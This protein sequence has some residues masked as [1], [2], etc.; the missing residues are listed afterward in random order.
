MKELLQLRQLIAMLLVLSIA[1]TSCKCGGDKKEDK[2]EMYDTKKPITSFREGI[3]NM[4]EL[5]QK[6]I[7][8]GLS[9][10]F[11][12]ALWKDRLAEALKLK[13][14]DE[15]KNLLQAAM[16]RI[17]Q[18]IYVDTSIQRREFESFMTD[19]APK[20]R[21]AFKGEDSA[22]FSQIVEHLGEP[23]KAGLIMQAGNGEKVDCDCVLAGAILNCPL[24]HN[25]EK[26]DCS[27]N[28]CGLFW[29]WY[30]DGLCVYKSPL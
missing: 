23:N 30:C 29:Y 18:G 26:K 15:Q 14:T 3:V 20:A 24:H 27:P 9:N 13:W 12:Q 28:R 11:K 10:E 19:W 7:F 4:H 25:C 6:K 21:G 2:M 16:D 5:D 1:F 8:D 17:N 22:R